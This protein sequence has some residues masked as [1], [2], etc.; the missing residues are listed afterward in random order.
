MGARA[1]Q[2]T[3]RADFLFNLAK[4]HNLKVHNMR[5]AATLENALIKAGI[6][7]PS[8]PP[9]EATQKGMQ[10]G[11]VTGSYKVSLVFRSLL[12]SLITAQNGTRQHAL[13]LFFGCIIAFV[14]Y[15]LYNCSYLLSK[16][17]PK[18][19]SFWE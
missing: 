2:R 15:L 13:L 3:P 16:D 10:N 4:Q 14:A 18:D 8:L 9:E 5:K 19:K 1:T 17:P 11:S 12:Q 7:I 6:P